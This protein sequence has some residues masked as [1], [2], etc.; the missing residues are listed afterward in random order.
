MA[1]VVAVVVVVVLAATELALELEGKD[2]SIECNSSEP[3][4]LRCF[5]RLFCALVWVCL[6]CV[7]DAPRCHAFE[8]HFAVALCSIRN[9]F[10]TGSFLFSVQ[11]L[12]PV[13]PLLKLNV[14]ENLFVVVLLHRLQDSLQVLGFEGHFAMVSRGA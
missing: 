14:V 2:Q 9:T 4:S 5:R 11:N 3:T 6:F 12:H 13:L 8:A 7:F 10:G 1:V